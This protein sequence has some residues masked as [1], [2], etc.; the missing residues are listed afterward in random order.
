M[1]ITRVHRSPRI[2]SFRL[3]LDRRHNGPLTSAVGPEGRHNT[4]PSTI[5]IYIYPMIERSSDR[6]LRVS[7][8]DECFVEK[9]RFPNTTRLKRR[10]KRNARMCAGTHTVSRDD[11]VSRATFFHTAFALLVA[12][13]SRK[14][15]MCTFVP[16]VIR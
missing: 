8:P 10:T 7:A 15:R 13:T 1:F 12:S 2:S 6:T 11:H 3:V 4:S 9:S 5:N 16:D 14:I